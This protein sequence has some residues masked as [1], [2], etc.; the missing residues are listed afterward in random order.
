[1]AEPP[2]GWRQRVVFRR[3]ERGQSGF[4]APQRTIVRASKEPVAARRL[5]KE[6]TDVNFVL[7]AK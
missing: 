2:V 6:D 3:D 7:A 5:Y 4:Y 1:V